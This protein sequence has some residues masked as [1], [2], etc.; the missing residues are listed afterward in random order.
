MTIYKNKNYWALLAFNFCQNNF[1]LNF[2]ENVYPK[3]KSRLCTSC[4]RRVN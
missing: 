2:W 1:R 3:T 4:I